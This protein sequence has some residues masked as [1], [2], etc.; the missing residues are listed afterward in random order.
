MSFVEKKKARRRCCWNCNIWAKWLTYHQS[1]YCLYYNGIPE[2]VR[3]RS[4]LNVVQYLKFHCQKVE[5]TRNGKLR[6]LSGRFQTVPGSQIVGKMRKCR[7][8][9]NGGG[10]GKK[11]KRGGRE[12]VIISF[13]TLFRRL[14][15]S[16]VSSS[17]FF[18]AFSIPLARLSRSL[19]QANFIL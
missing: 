16:P 13:T 1:H 14:P 12:R 3:K 11:G 6:R 5:S 19:E 17:F 8:R 10:A 18:R 15:L 4:M 7:A 2:F 9:E